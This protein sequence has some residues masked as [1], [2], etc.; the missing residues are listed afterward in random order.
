M[1]SPC[2]HGY[3]LAYVDIH[4]HLHWYGIKSEHGAKNGSCYIV[5]SQ[6]Y[7]YCALKL[8]SCCEVVDRIGYLTPGLWGTGLHTLQQWLT[9][10]Y[11]RI[12]EFDEKYAQHTASDCQYRA[13]GEF[14]YID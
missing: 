13:F 12:S 14:V 4:S 9:G 8:C 5:I 2:S 1:H 6:H 3:E 10:G 11:S 7:G